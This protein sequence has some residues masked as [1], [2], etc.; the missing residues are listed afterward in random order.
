MD[1]MNGPERFRMVLGNLLKEG[2][3][4]DKIINLLSDT[5]GIPQAL[6]LNQ[7]AKKAVDFLRQEKVRVKTIQRS[8]CHAK[9][10][11]YHDPD[12]RKNF[13]VI[14]SSNLTDA[15]M[16]IRESGN[17]ELNSASTGNDN[18]F[19]E[20]TQWFSDLW[21]SKDALGNIELPDKSKV[22]VKEHIITLI[23]YLYSKYT[24]FQLYYKVLYELFKEDLLSL[25]LD[26]EFKKE[27][28]IGRASCRERV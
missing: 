12:T 13:H 25:S 23:Q 22:S 3:Q 17:I 5:L 2:A 14:G 10:Y 24:P 16:G 27:I 20:L 9:T 6:N 7:S 19:K 15:G 8:F 21:K 11:M 1:E 18:D 4:Q 28:K 26:P